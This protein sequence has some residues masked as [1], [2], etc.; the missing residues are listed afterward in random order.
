MEKDCNGRPPLG[1][2]SS[3]LCLTLLTC[4]MGQHLLEQ[5]VELD[6][7][8]GRKGTDSA[9]G[10]APCYLPLGPPPGPSKSLLR[11]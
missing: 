5:S 1:K 2:G 3:P 4:K 6:E 11:S 8:V 10:P 9:R 7:A